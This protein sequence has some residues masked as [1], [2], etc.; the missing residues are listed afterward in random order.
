LVESENRKV[1]TNMV[2]MW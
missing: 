2:V 1:A